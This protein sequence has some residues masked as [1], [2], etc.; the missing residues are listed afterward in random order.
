MGILNFENAP[1]EPIERVMWLSGVAEAVAAEMDAAWSEAYFN[2]RLRGR[3]QLDAAI[4]AG[5]HSR[6]RVLAYTR[7]ENERRAR[8]IRWGD[9]ADPTSTAYSG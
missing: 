9:G 6:K 8:I 2:A 3:A 1:T 5:P 7:A 4:S